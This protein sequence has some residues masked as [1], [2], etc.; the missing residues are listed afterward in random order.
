MKRTPCRHA[1]FPL[2]RHAA[3]LAAKLLLST[4]LEILS[5]ELLFLRR[6]CR[7]WA[8]KRAV[9]LRCSALLEHRR[10]MES[11]VL[12]IGA[13]TAWISSALARFRTSVYNVVLIFCKNFAPVVPASQTDC[14][15]IVNASCDKVGML[16]RTGKQV[17]RKV[18]V[19][20]PAQEPI[21]TEHRGVSIFM[22]WYLNAVQSKVQRWARGLKA[23]SQNHTL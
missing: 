21:A 1:H 20:I 10:S 17:A 14:R 13:P 19:S 23:L 4:W 12:L 18:I 15:T 5:K 22:V 11:L 6:I 16:G 2:M 8:K 7:A 9:A 3:R